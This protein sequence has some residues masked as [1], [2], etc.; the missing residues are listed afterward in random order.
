MKLP[1]G[2]NLKNGEYTVKEAIGQGGFGITYK[3]VWNTSVKGN[4]GAINAQLPVAIKEFF[5][6]DYCV[7]EGDTKNITI[8]SQT[9]KELFGKFKEK[10]IKEANILSNL[11]HPNIV[12]VLEVFE[13]NNTAYMIM[14]YLEGEPLKDVLKRE[15]KLGIAQATDYIKQIADA[16]DEVHSKN[17]LHLDIK[18]GNIIIAQ[19]DGKPMLIDFGI[20]KR[21]NTDHGE[22]STTPTGRSKGYAPIEQYLDKGAA[23]FSPALDIYALGATYYHALT[24]TIPVEANERIINELQ[25]PSSL[26]KNVPASLDAVV[27]KMLELKKENRYQSISAFL[28]DLNKAVPSTEARVVADDKTQIFGAIED[29]KTG[30]GLVE[31][32]KPA[33]KPSEPQTVKSKLPAPEEEIEEDE[34][35]DFEVSNTD[36]KAAV[37]K[38]AKRVSTGGW[39]GILLPVLGL[40]GYYGI[41]EYLKKPVIENG[42]SID[43]LNEALTKSKAHRDSVYNDL[44]ARYVNGKSYA[45]YK[46]LKDFVAKNPEY[47]SRFDSLSAAVGVIVPLKLDTT[48]YTT[49]PSV[50]NPQDKVNE[51]KVAPKKENSSSISNSLKI[52]RKIDFDKEEI[53]QWEKLMLPTELENK[54]NGKSLVLFG[55]GILT[56][57]FL[58]N[59]KFN[60]NSKGRVLIKGTRV[61]TGVRNGE[62]VKLDGWG[63]FVTNDEIEYTGYVSSQLSENNN[64]YCDAMRKFKFRRI[65]G[66]SKFSASITDPCNS[67][68]SYKLSFVVNE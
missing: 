1:V 46:E 65:P 52:T 30:I 7:R 36:A 41:K 39:F 37:K 60:R 40:V 16:L 45:T 27:M 2:T 31:K 56:D 53:S 21:Y 12:R 63:L 26:N 20:S 47:Q 44:S 49:N 43:K 14:D 13:E 9:G 61:G 15:G 54:V 25:P 28:D 22:T 33:P 38:P 57:N 11:V 59:I 6:E 34:D 19:R 4:L 55:S 10:L 66:T 67:N 50:P 48:K 51:A 42:I 29:D 24:G 17:I 68:L 5:F 23:S 32:N 3:G 62:V 18:P 64:Q 58:G 8:H 35:E